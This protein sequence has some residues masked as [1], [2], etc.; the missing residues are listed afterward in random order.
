MP[1]KKSEYHDGLL[2]RQF[3]WV[4]EALGAEHEPV[5][6]GAK[7]HGW[8]LMKQRGKFRV[9]TWAGDTPL[10]GDIL[11]R[12]ECYLVFEAVLKASGKEWATESETAADIQVRELST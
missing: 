8:Y 3:E 10:G 4:C 6:N 11:N 5:W 2:D 1:R 12:R 9:E 7:R